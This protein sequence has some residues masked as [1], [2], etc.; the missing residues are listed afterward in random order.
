M[1][2]ECGP[3]F[4]QHHSPCTT[5]V[6]RPCWCVLTG[7]TWRCFSSTSRATRLVSAGAPSKYY[8]IP[9]RRKSS[10]ECFRWSYRRTTTAFQA[11]VLPAAYVVCCRIIIRKT[12]Y[13]KNLSCCRETARP[14]V[15]FRKVIT[16]KEIHKS[17]QMSLYKMYTLPLCISYQIKTF[18]FFFLTLTLKLNREPILDHKGGIHM[19]LFSG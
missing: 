15:L 17:C 9:C 10:I 4:W 13:S 7:T 19:F 3:R 11:L 14:S 16:H 6:I 2:T 8:L 1:W 18:N 12:C 5:A